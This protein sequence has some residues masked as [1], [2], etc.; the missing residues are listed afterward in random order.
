MN[1]PTHTG[2]HSTISFYYFCRT[3]W[4]EDEHNRRSVL[5]VRVYV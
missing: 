3:R 2:S 4:N 1:A 5:G